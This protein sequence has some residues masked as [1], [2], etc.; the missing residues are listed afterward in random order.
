MLAVEELV[1]V[2]RRVPALSPAVQP[3][4]RGGSSGSA[5]ASLPGCQ[6]RGCAASFPGSSG[7]GESAGELIILVTVGRAGTVPGGTSS[8]VFGKGCETIDQR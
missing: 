8:V 6:R 4:A 1:E 7:A 3:L 2:G 5:R